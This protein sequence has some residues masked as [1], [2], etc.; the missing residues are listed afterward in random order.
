MFFT[1]TNPHRLPALKPGETAFAFP[2]VNARYLSCRG[3]PGS[4]PPFYFPLES[5][6]PAPATGHCD[7]APGSPVL[8]HPLSSGSGTVARAAM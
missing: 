3:K 4:R 8:C 6:K 2:E 5:S 1:R 7:A